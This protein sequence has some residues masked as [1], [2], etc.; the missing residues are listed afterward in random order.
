MGQGSSL[1]LFDSTSGKKSWPNSYDVT[2]HPD[3]SDEE[4][5][6]TLRSERLETSSEESADAEEQGELKNFQGNKEECKLVLVVRT[7]LGMGKGCTIFIV[8][9][10]SRSKRGRQDRGAMF[11][12]YTSM[13]QIFSLTCTQVT[14]PET[15]GTAWTGESRLASKDRGTIGDA[16]GASGQL[17]D[18]R[19]GD[20]R[21]REDADCKRFGDSLRHWTGAEE[22]Y[23]SGHRSS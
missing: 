16:A 10:M 22:C 21:C 23:R 20:S 7:D 4:L 18:L 12:C 17:G 14:D 15:M 19:S 5:M 8:R 6:K 9:T 1:G 11:S 13:L 2:V 3:S